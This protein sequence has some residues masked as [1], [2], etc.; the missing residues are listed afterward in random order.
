MKSVGGKGGANN[1]TL[2]DQN[3]LI[4]LLKARNKTLESEIQDLHNKMATIGSHQSHAPHQTAGDKS[5]MNNLKSGF[6]SQK[7]AFDRTKNALEETTQQLLEERRRNSNLESELRTAQAKASEAKDLHIMLEDSKMEKR[8]LEARIKDLT[9][10]PFFRDNEAIAPA[11][12]KETQDQL[13]E[14]KRKM[15]EIREANFSHEKLVAELKAQLKIVAEERD[16]YRDEK[17]KFE[18][19]LLERERAHS[20]MDEQMKGLNVIP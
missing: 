18:A 15:E 9:S 10:S 6:E 4:D 8:M 12:F 20:F 17:N 16:K 1:K 13:H 14:A 19:T 5:Y 3:R 7:A 11:R 2:S